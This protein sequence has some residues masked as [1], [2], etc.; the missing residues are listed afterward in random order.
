MSSRRVL[1]VDDDESIRVVAEVALESVAGWQ[2]RTADGGVTGLA[3]AAEHRPD[4]ILLDVMMPGLDGL[5]TFRLLQED[6]VTREIPVVLVTAKVAHGDRADWDG[7]AIAGVIPKPF[8]PMTLGRQV[9]EMLG[10]Q[11]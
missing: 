5:A 7:L 3:L 8:D 10:W 4:V 9:A 1:V 6:P 2:V 11:P